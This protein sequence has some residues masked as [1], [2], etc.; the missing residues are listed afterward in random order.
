MAKKIALSPAAIDGVTKGTLADL[1]TPGLA[2]EVLPSGKKRWRYRRQIAG[3]TVVV[4]MFG[5]LYPARAISEARAWAR[6]QNEK[7]EAGLDPRAI[8]RDERARAEMTVAKAH[9]LYMT[10]AREGRSSRAKRPNKEKTIAGK[11]KIYKANIAPTLSHRSIYDVTEDDLVRLVEKKGRTAKSMANRLAVELGVFFG[12]ASSLKGCEVGLTFNPAKRLHDL[13]FPES[14]RGRILDVQ[15]IGWFLQSLVPESRH[16]QRGFLLLLLSAARISEVRQA[17]TSEIHGD[18]WIIPASRTKS[19]REHR[20]AL[21]PWGRSLMVSN[22][23]WIF[24]SPVN[25]G[26]LAHGI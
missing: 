20:I 17:K 14:P 16:F 22:H 1:L 8:Q 12:W 9:E 2:I 7:V 5:G 24:P 6:E 26:P 3:S 25:D 18:M 4:T 11:I 19:S 10:A 15:E 21:G 13:H 23:E